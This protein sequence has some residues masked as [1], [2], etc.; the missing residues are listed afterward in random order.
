MMQ[1][2]M[3]DSRRDLADRLMDG[4]LRDFIRT[5]RQGGS[6]Y[7]TISVRLREEHGISVNPASVR[8]WAIDMNVHGPEAVA[9]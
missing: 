5:A 2:I 8:R 7:F 6:S 1:F 3:N 4:G 9:S